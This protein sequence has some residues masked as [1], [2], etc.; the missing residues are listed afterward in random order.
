[1]RRSRAHL[2]P[3]EDGLSLIEILITVS[4]MSIAIVPL[5]SSL[6][7]IVVYSDADRRG[8]LAEGDVRRFAEVV[9]SAKYREC[10]DAA[11]GA[12]AYTEGYSDD[13]SLVRTVVRVEFWDYT[14]DAFVAKAASTCASVDAPQDPG[15]QRVTV[16]VTANG[17]IS[18]EREIALVKRRGG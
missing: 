11:S 10:A 16:K 5:A 8:A 6:L 18:R 14:T 1:M 15:I 12:Y 3:G 7:S 4:I 17:S 9:R 2:G 13:T